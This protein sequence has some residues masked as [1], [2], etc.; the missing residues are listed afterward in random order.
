MAAKET[1]NGTTAL[2]EMKETKIENPTA[3]N[4]AAKNGSNGDNGGYTADS[5]KVLGG[6]EAEHFNGIGGIASVVTIAAILRCAVLSGWIFDFR[7]FHFGEC[8]RSVTRF[9]RGH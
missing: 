1:R 4:G 3:K 9:L 6:M 7:L 2:A 5:I 8:R